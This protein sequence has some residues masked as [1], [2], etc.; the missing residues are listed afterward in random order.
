MAILPESMNGLSEQNVAASLRTI[1]S[2]IHYMGE[3]IEFSVSGITKDLGVAKTEASGLSGR[4]GAIEERISSIE[5]A[6][7]SLSQRVAALESKQT[8]QTS[9]ETEE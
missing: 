3:R 1:E 5:N 6:L 4:I 8:A 9:A 2:Y 7:S